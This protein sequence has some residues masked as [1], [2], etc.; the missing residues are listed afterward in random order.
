MHSLLL[1]K[2][3][4]LLSLGILLIVATGIF[5]IEIKKS[6]DYIIEDKVYDDD[7]IYFGN[8]VDFLG[9]ADDIYFF[10]E[11]LNFSGESNSSI[12]AFGQNIIIAGKVGNNLTT[13]ADSIQINGNIDG[14]AFIAGDTILINNEAEINGTVF[15]AGSKIKILGEINGDLYI[16]SGKIVIEGIINGNIL[17]STGKLSITESGKVNGNLKYYSEFKLSDEEVSRV[18]GTVKYEKH[19][20]RGENFF[21]HNCKGFLIAFQFFLLISLLVTGLLFLLFPAMK[22]LEEDRS[23]KNY[24]YSLLWGLIPFFI[25]PVLIIVL[26]PTIVGI[27]LSLLLLLAGLPILITTQII[28]ITITGQYLFKLFKWDKPVRFLHFLFGFI[29]F[30]ILSILP[31]I[32]FLTKIFFSSLGWG[33]I[34]Q[35]LFNKK[36]TD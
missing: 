19:S 14:T 12:T 9:K 35:S 10:G 13:A 20:R 34:L 22:K 27:P 30:V 24:W 11:T 15:A 1:A 3:R 31:I 23:S 7:Y 28:G 21:K 2:K 26:L 8:S 17:T 16:G 25:Y 5:S 6:D 4:L 36:F 32:G 29:F 18:N 33:V